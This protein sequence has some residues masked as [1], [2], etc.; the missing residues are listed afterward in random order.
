MTFHVRELRRAQ[1]DIRHIFSW[2]AER[3]PQGARAWLD[4]YDAMVARLEQSADALGPADENKDCEFD[5]R[6]ALFKTSRGR[7]YR[8]IFFIEGDEVFIVRV[9]G[10]G[11]APVQP[12]DLA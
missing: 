12:D 3:S 6:Q 2:L 1:A 9:R 8:A 11:Q 10:P 7:V 4:A 5:V